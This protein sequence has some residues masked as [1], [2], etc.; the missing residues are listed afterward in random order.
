MTTVKKEMKENK[1][2]RFEFQ[3]ETKKLLSLMISSIYSN[4][5]I[6]LRELISNA[7][8][9]LDK[10][11]F[12]A[13]TQADLIK[14]DGKQEIRIEYDKKLRTLTIHDN[15]IGMNR[16]ELISNIGTIAK[17]GTEELMKKIQKAKENNDQSQTAEM[18]GQFGVGFYSV[19]MVADKVD[20]LTSKAGTSK[21]IL[22]TSTGDGSY[23]IEDVK[24][25]SHGTSVTLYLKDSE[26]NAGLDDFTESYVIE[27]VVKKYSDFIN[28][29]IILK[30][31]RKE[32]EKDK[33]GKVIEGGKTEIVIEDKVLNSMKPIWTRQ[34]NEV[35]DEEYEE[36]Y[37][38][39][40]HDW[41]KPF[42]II[43]FKAE[44]R[45]EYTSL[46]FLPAQAPFDLFYQNYKS[47]LQL[48]V[49]KILIVE[50]FEDLL[51]TYLRFVKGVVDSPSLPLNI[52]REMLQKDIHITL[53]KKGL[54]SKILSIL[55]QIFEKEHD[56]YIEF[57]KEFGVA[58]KEGLTSDYENKDKLLNLLLYPS[59]FSEDKLT[60]LKQYKERMPDGQKNIYYVAG[61]SREMV[62]NSPHIEKFRERGYEILYLLDPIDEMVVNSIGEFDKKKL[63]SVEAGFE[64]LVDQKD[65][66]KSEKELKAK[67][68]EMSD[69]LKNLQKKLDNYVKEVKVT[70]R[71]V[72]AP[73]CVV[74]DS[75]SGI[76]LHL[77]KLLKKSG[78]ETP[79]SKKILE[80]NPAHPIITKLHTRFKND[81]NDSI[82]EEYAELLY[83]YGMLA[84]GREIDNIGKFS[85]LISQVMEKAI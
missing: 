7:S 49:K 25:D 56:K 75:A 15:G 76:S 19:F 78:Q 59:S 64:E 62:E 61:D 60:S 40:A 81:K 48:Y 41:N 51:P 30:D 34:K 5:E 84:E 39:I 10:L 58:L 13:L 17:S 18:I 1:K 8:D 28:Y 37:K 42:R 14:P 31:E 74:G 53:I 4:K 68:E 67:E 43:P 83:G 45:I 27:K 82:I 47:G 79:S 20:L 72:S 70:D 16:K 46:L 71:L 3:A 36:F 33:D 52:S 12:A 77:E 26:P 2:E 80:L 69:L 63:V 11:N 54:T 57:W 21:A 38:H 44:G 73:A 24:S 35:K 66:E 9:A 50:N 29:S 23:E 55:K 6:F 32:V 22:W 65:K 85:K